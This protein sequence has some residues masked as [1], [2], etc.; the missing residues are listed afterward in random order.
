V[1]AILDIPRAPHISP[2][3]AQTDNVIH[4]RR[5]QMKQFDIEYV[6]AQF[7]ALSRT[8]NGYPVAY[9]DGPGGTQVP[10]R[11]VD[12]V[13]DYLLNHNCNIHGLFAT[14]EE[15]DAIIDNAHR[16]LADLLGADW[17]EVSFG[18]NMTT[19]TIFVA[20][21]LAR[22]W[23]PGDEVVI[24]SLD[25]EADRGPWLLLEE[26]GLVVREVPVDL[27]ECTLV[28]DELERLVNNRTRLVALGYASNATGTVNDVERAADLAHSVGAFCYVDAVHYALH[29]AIDVKDID[30]DFLVCSPYK[31]FGPH[32]GVLYVK[33][34]A[35]DRI[36]P[37]K[38]ETQEEEPPYRF[39]TGTLCHE[40]IAGA[41][42]AVEF[43]ADLGRHHDEAGECLDRRGAVVAGMHAMETYEQP[44][45]QRLVDGL[46]ALPGLRIFG[47]PAGSPRTSTVSFSLEGHPA[48]E[49]ARAL[50]EQGLFVW[51]GDFYAARLVQLADLADKGGLLR[52]GL[53]PY[54]TAGEV[55]RVIAAVAALARSAS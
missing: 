6:R 40:G 19:L 20:Q 30:C 23:R 15:T 48:P 46:S 47:P 37:L 18:T 25:H 22:D 43:I 17:T 31:F 52:I 28:W 27:E 7:P 9:L 54:N 3:P 10:Q 39:E 45:A 21:S 11:V 44:L 55:E 51:D 2:T 35:N 32:M 53:C 8:V 14:S 26:R 41:A 4:E 13:T 34:S 12:A 38:L 24:T 49:M 42:E 33:G 36:R 1:R 16:A 50:G 5:Q 29:G